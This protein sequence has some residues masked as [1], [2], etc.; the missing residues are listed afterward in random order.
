MFWSLELMFAGAESA[1]DIP[2]D[3]LGS[4]AGAAAAA[5]EPPPTE[6]M[7]GDESLAE[8]ISEVVGSVVESSGK[9]HLRS[10]VEIGRTAYNDDNPL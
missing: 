7:L 1:V 2:P 8:L 6:L 9:E 3:E 5:A 10:N 4:G